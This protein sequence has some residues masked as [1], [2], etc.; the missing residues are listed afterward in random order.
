MILSD[1][2]KNGLIILNGM[3]KRISKYQKKTSSEFYFG[4]PPS[5]FN[6]M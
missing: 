4:N 5:I 6:V 3:A 2:N 1:E